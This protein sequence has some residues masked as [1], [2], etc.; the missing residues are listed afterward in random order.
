MV[1]YCGSRTSFTR[2][3]TFVFIWMLP[4]FQYGLIP[5]PIPMSNRRWIASTLPTV[6]FSIKPNKKSYPLTRRVSMTQSIWLLLGGGT[7]NILTAWPAEV[8]HAGE[9][10]SVTPLGRNIPSSS[11]SSQQEDLLKNFGEKLQQQKQQLSPS[12][13][14]SPLSP[15]STEVTTNSLSDMEQA[16]QQSRQRRQVNPQSH[17]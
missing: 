8:T 1:S 4:R 14:V 17:G 6:L 5:S 13:L 7:L 11:S 15:T 9:S 2:V 12:S 3:L 16:L 10:S